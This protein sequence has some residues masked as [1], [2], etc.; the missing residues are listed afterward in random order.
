MKFFAVQDYLYTADYHDFVAGETTQSFE[1]PLTYNF[2]RTIKFRAGA[3]LGTNELNMTT[4]E[5][6]VPLGHLVNIRNVSGGTI[7]TT[8]PN[9]FITVTFEIRTA[10]PQLNPYGTVEAFQYTLMRVE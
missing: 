7:Y 4:P 10:L 1:T 6:L 3:L 8:D 5:L 9:D 2:N